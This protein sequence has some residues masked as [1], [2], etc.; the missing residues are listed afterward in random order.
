MANARRSNVLGLAGKLKIGPS[1][2][3]LPWTNV[4]CISAQLLTE[5]KVMFDF[6]LKSISKL[7]LTTKPSKYFSNMPISSFMLLL[8]RN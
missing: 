3:P 4:W 8:K 7:G 5:F 1:E 2:G 6:N